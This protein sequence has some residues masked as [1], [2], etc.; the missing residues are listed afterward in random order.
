M[1]AT[2]QTTLEA[3]HELSFVSNKEKLQSRLIVFADRKGGVVYEWNKV[4]FSVPWYELSD[5]GKASSLRFS[6]S[7]KSPREGSF[8]TFA[9]VRA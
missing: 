8:T 2:G 9:D 6:T 4:L 3:G 7:V 5:F 1:A